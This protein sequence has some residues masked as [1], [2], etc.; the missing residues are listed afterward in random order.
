M[1]LTREQIMERVRVAQ[2]TLSTTRTDIFATD[3]PEKTLRYIILIIIYGDCVAS[4]TV[5]VEKK[6]EDGTYKMKYDNVPIAPADARSIPPNG[7]D[8]EKPILVLEG[9]TNL[10]FTASAGAP[11]VSVLYWDSEIG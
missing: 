1:K 6:K 8:I 2:L 7:W 9:G 10:A 4:R 5:E 3:V 11:E